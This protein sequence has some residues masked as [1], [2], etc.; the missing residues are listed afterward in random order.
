MKRI[1]IPTLLL[2]VTLLFHAVG[3]YSQQPANP[4]Q[5]RIQQTEDGA[6]YRFSVNVVERF[7][8]AINYRHRG[9]STG[10]D[11]RGTGLMPSA[12]GEAKVESKQ[13]YTEIEVE[14]DDLDPA[15]RFGPEFLTYV[16]WAVT[17][18]GRATNLGEVI[19]NGTKSKL[20]V[21]SELQTFAMIVT[22][23]PYFAVSQPSDVVVLENVIREDTSTKFDFVNAKY[24]LLQRGQYTANVV[25]ADLKPLLLEKDTALDLLEAR[26]AV[27][28]A[29]WAGAEEYASDTFRKAAA[30]LTLAENHKRNK[31][32]ARAIAMASREAV[33][34]S[35]DARLIAMKRTDDKRIADERQAAEARASEARTRAA[36]EVQKAEREA[37]LRA[38]ALA[39]EAEARA[40]AER[41]RQEA[42]AAELRAKEATA[43]ADA[44]TQ[45][46]RQAERERALLKA[47]TDQEK[48]TL[49]AELSAQLNRVL[50][51]RESARGLIV[52][53][54]DVLFDFGKHTLRP[55]ARE[56][57]A[58]VSGILL[59][60]P[61]LTLEVEG[62][63]DDVGSDSFNQQL[64]EQRADTVR[65]YLRQQGLPEVSARGFGENRPLVAND[66][67]T[68][69]QKN[70]RV[71]MVVSGESIGL[72]ATALSRNR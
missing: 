6:L 17:P 60:H 55:E 30:L 10:I 53:M 72:T 69:R 64:S 22:A 59:S 44:E 24:E 13:G 15:T 51:T 65:D 61:G 26:N 20:N 3:S 25:P 49:R 48:A 21:T 50:A 7:A 11:F 27:R 29:R 34:A 32:G 28:I 5:T 47:Q 33:Q 4:T 37:R 63:T 58:K 19:L 56:N 14:F 36:Q 31:A 52:S 70:R 40:S 41:A 2:C 71:E 54:P 66:S 12:R 43:L 16:M 62:H 38:E 45:R 46:A 35:E 67:S 18:E 68:N 39:G 9:G 23:E 57:L 8:T 42:A 1:K